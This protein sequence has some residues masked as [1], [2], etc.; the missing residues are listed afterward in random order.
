MNEEQLVRKE[1]GTG[2][3]I[4]FIQRGGVMTAA[5]DPQTGE[6][7]P[8]DQ[9]GTSKGW[10]AVTSDRRVFYGYFGGLGGAKF[11]GTFGFSRWD[12][13][14]RGLALLNEGLGPV[15]LCIFVP[16]T[17]APDALRASMNKEFGSAG[18]LDRHQ[19]DE[20]RTL[21]ELYANRVSLGGMLTAELREI[22][23]IYG[24]LRDLGAGAD[25]KLVDQQKALNADAIPPGNYP[26][27]KYH[28]PHLNREW[29]DRERP[30]R[31][32]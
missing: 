13:D 25:Q 16:M 4:V 7:F 9:F 19:D 1:L 20:V 26:F 8:I 10:L 17:I 24:R 23:E 28:E 3:R 11:G 31:A 14:P 6:P 2:E 32:P 27:G 29:F 12:D 15:D 30:D 21:Q 18:G 5:L 22:N